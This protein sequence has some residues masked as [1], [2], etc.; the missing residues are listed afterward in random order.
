ML[1][2]DYIVAQVYYQFIRELESVGGI[3]SLTAYP[4]AGGYS[5]GHGHYGVDKGMTITHEQAEQFLHEDIIKAV[6]QMRRYINDDA[7]AQMNSNQITALVSLFYNVGWQSDWKFHGYINS[8]IWHP[9]IYA[10]WLTFRMSQGQVIPALEIRRQKEVDLYYSDFSCANAA[11][12]PIIQQP[13]PT[14]QTFIT[15][16]TEPIT[17]GCVLPQMQAP[18]PPKESPKKG[19]STQKKALLIVLIVAMALTI[20]TFALC[21]EKPKIKAQ[22]AMF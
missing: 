4:D 18:L 1:T 12:E 19:K 20:T 6:Q 11:D 3:P 15:Q 10:E 2:L 9:Q 21:M 8:D 5:I 22:S 14:E 16:P 7:I 13:Q 17:Q